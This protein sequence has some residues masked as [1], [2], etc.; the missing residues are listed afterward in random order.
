MVTRA[1]GQPLP[2]EGSS[3]LRDGGRSCGEKVRQYDVDRLHERHES[4][5]G[6]S[7][8]NIDSSTVRT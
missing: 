2:L 4:A 6:D 5:W 1:F 7:A 8:A 3:P